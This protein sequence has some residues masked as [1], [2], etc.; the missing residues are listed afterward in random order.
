MTKSDSKARTRGMRR[1]AGIALSLML[2]AGALTACGSGGETIAADAKTG[3]R[4]IRIAAPFISTMNSAVLYAQ[5][6][7]IFAKHNIETEFVEVHGAAGLQATLGGSTDMAI[8]SSVNPVAALEQGQEFPIIA[9]IGNGFPESVLITAAAWK[10]SGLKDDSPLKDKMKFLAGKAWGV[11][12]PQG[13][14]SYMARYMFQLAGLSGDDFKMNSMGSASGTLAG[15]KSEK[16]VAGSMGSPYPQVAEAEGY[17]KLFINVSGGEVP[18]LTNTLTSVVAVTPDF[19]KNN[20]ELVADF[21]K[22]LGEA[23]KLVYEKSAEVDEWI[24]KNHFDGSPKEAVLAGVKD[25]RDG[26]AIAKQPEVSAESAERLVA[27]MKAT[28]QPVP[29]DWR[30]IFVDLAG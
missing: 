19:Y 29:D 15:L 9:Q 24:Y 10:E 26:A 22:A 14:S 28:G 20:K 16:V 3:N 17:A 30:K 27:F 6:N 2:G 5:G 8:T 21:R 7:G 13:S 11:S 25:Q 1:L 12:S 23:Q 4:K 18:E